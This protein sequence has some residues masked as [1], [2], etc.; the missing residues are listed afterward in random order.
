VPAPVPVPV[1]AVTL[2]ASTIAAKAAKPAAMP[3]VVPSSSTRGE[4]VVLQQAFNTSPSVFVKRM[5]AACRA[6][7]SGQVDLLLGLWVPHPVAEI[8]RR[9][10]PI[11]QCYWQAIPMVVGTSVGATLD[12]V[13]ITMAAP[14]VNWVLSPQGTQTLQG[15]PS[16]AASE[17]V[18]QGVLHSHAFDDVPP[19]HVAVVLPRTP[20]PSQGLSALACQH[21]T[22]M[23]LGHLQ[24]AQ[25]AAMFVWVDKEIMHPQLQA[26]A[27]MGVIHNS[28]V[29][30][31]V[32]M[33]TTGLVR[34]PSGGSTAYLKAVDV[35]CVKLNACT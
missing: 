25:K 1:S 20:K 15:L 7:R 10:L 14:R 35:L 17:F 8:L 27:N 16:G 30:P 5:V 24:R 2:S 6:L 12:L 29:A 11:A 9:Q 26:L 23:L 22:A 31:R 28:T 18:L 13:I 32:K 33:L 19:L 3:A 4:C 21:V 34:P